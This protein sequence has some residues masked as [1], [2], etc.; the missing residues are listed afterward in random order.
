MTTK[1]YPTEYLWRWRERLE[2]ELRVSLLK[3]VNENAPFARRFAWS[4]L[5]DEAM[6]PTIMDESLLVLMGYIEKSTV[7]PTPENLRLRLRSEIKRATKKLARRQRMEAPV[8]LLPNLELLESPSRAL[9]LDPTDAVLLFEIVELL[10]PRARE[11]ADWIR[12]GYTWRE[13]GRSMEI[14]HASIQRSFRREV[15]LALL[16]LGVDLRSQM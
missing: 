14:S 5:Q 16:K 1:T 2:P 9:S 10:S 4:L 7:P 11:V 6:E 8:G 3:A 13:I 15:D 12:L